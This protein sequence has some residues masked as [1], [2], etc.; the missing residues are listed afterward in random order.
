MQYIY[1]EEC[2]KDRENAEQLIESYKR[3][4]DLL[5]KE[6]EEEDE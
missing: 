6:Q 2:F 1:D 5:T 4:I 3:A